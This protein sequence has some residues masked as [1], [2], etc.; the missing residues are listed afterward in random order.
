MKKG[1]GS[2]KSQKESVISSHQLSD[3]EASGYDIYQG[4]KKQMLRSQEILSKNKK[5]ENEMEPSYETDENKSD[6]K[7]QEEVLGKPP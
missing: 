5:K 2:S 7:V 6:K 4:E 1:V 3:S